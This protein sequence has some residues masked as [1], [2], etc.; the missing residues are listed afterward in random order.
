MPTLGAG[1]FFVLFFMRNSANLYNKQLEHNEEIYINQ[2]RKEK[3]RKA[4]EVKSE[5]RQGEKSE[6]RQGSFI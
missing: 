1:L 3:I 4:V 2:N 6:S 5:S